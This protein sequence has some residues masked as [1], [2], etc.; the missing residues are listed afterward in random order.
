[1]SNYQT[2]AI[3]VGGG[4]VGLAIARAIAATGRETIVLE[5]QAGVARETSSRNSGVMHAGIYYAPGSLKARLCAPG[6]AMLQRYC[7]DKGVDFQQCG[8]LIVATG[9]QDASA[10]PSLRDKARGNGV[11]DIE[12]LEGR[13][14][15]RLEPEVAC[16]AALHCGDT[17]IV[18]A[19]AYAA[20]LAG[21]LTAAGGAIALGTTAVAVIPTGDSICVQATDGETE[22][23]IAAPLVINAAGHGAP[24]MARATRGLADHGQPQQWFAKGNYFA[25]TGRNPFS[26]LVYPVGA[27]ASGLAA[28]LGVHATID[29]GGQLR[30][31]PDVEWVE[32]ED[33]YTVSAH[34]LEMFE[35]A[36]RDWWPDL[37]AGALAPA[38]AGVRPKLH[39][40]GE[41]AP[42]FRIDGP[43]VHGVP[44]LVNLFGI[45]SPGLT[46][47]LAIAEHVMA[48]LTD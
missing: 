12:L 32:A 9:D 48:M 39:G 44:G 26:H 2:D 40:P 41:P 15:R 8:K 25:F 5:R 10:L 43:S 42:D 29:L 35:A 47:S 3:V 19:L 6:R 22:T 34:R 45:E 13:E 18:D 17:G 7:A 4:V 31:G 28:G 16:V 21:D 38:W 14:V 27:A 37:P 23:E 36:I 20:R 11:A 33:D 1:M 46:A 30:F 24:R